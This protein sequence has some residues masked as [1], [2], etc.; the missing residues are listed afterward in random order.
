MANPNQPAKT[1]DW[2]SLVRQA[3]P[4]AEK[5]QL[6]YPFRKPKYERVL[7]PGSAKP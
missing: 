7:P 5:L 4:R 3:E 6:V 1:I 2:A